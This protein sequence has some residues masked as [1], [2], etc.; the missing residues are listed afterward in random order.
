M[1]DDILTTIIPLSHKK[2]VKNHPWANIL[3]ELLPTDWESGGMGS[4]GMGS[5]V[6]W[7]GEGVGI[8][9]LSFNLEGDPNYSPTKTVFL[10][11]KQ[12]IKG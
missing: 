3:I 6:V 1:E 7:S 11:S 4:G 9:K 8:F 12:P 10:E 5:G 2:L